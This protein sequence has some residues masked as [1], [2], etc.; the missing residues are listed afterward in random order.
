MSDDM[1]KLTDE[2]L[3]ERLAEHTCFGAIFCG[4]P[5]AAA[6][7]E[8]PAC[9]K[10]QLCDWEHSGPD[11]DGTLMS[12]PCGAVASHRLLIAH[13]A[14]DVVSTWFFCAEHHDAVIEDMR[15]DSESHIVDDALMGD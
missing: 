3:E 1:S 5:A 2:Q 6:Q 8:C 7:A 4:Q 10:S 11:F 15:N 12:Y 14:V 9:S 13:D